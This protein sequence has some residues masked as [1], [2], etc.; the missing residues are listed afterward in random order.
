MG[1]DAHPTVDTAALA[2]LLSLDWD[3]LAGQPDGR[4]RNPD[5]IPAL[6][7]DLAHNGCRR[8]LVIQQFPPGTSTVGLPG[9]VAR[10]VRTATRPVEVLADGHH[11]L[12]AALHAGVAEFPVIWWDE[13]G[14]PTAGPA[15]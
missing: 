15:R 10:R 4:L 9:H 5:T 6:A 3:G 12:A 1:L 7:A 8:P 11:R 2:Q 13:H 14:M